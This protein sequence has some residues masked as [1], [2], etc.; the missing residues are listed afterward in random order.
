MAFSELLRIVELG[1]TVTAETTAEV[2]SGATVIKSPTTG[3]Q[4][5]GEAYIAGERFSYTE[6]TGTE[7]KGVTGVANTHA[8]KAEVTVTG[9]PKTLLN[10]ND[11]VHYLE[12]AG[13]FEVIPPEPTPVLAQNQRRWGGSREVAEVHAN[14]AIEWTAGVT[15]ATEQEAI[16]RVE[17]LLAQ[18]AA[19]PYHTYVLWQVPGASHPT[20]FEMRGTGTWTPKYDV[21][22][23]E[24]AQ[25]FLLTIRVPVAPLALGWPVQV[26]SKS[27]LTLP[28]VL[29]ITGIP[30]DAPA[31]A[32]VSIETGS[33]V[34]ETF[35]TGA[36]EPTGIAI[37]SEFIYW[38]NRETGYIGRAKLNGTGV[39][40]T[41]LHV[42][43]EPI[44]VAVDAAHI[45]WCNRAGG[46][47]GR[48]TIAGATIEKTWITGATSPAGV[49][50]DASHVYWANSAAAGTIGRAAIAGGSIEQN[51][52]TG[53]SRP[54]GLA[55]NAAH[56]YW[57][58]ESGTGIGRAT[59]AGA[60]ASQ[61]WLAV[62]AGV[63]G[64]AI[65]TEYIYWTT[66]YPTNA[67]GRA[68][69]AGAEPNDAWLAAVAEGLAVSSEYV[70]AAL[71]P[72]N[73]ILRMK[74]GGNPVFGLLGWASKPT[75]GLAKAPFG[76]LTAS[77]S[78][79]RI[80]LNL[81]SVTGGTGGKSLK[82]TTR[83]GAASWEVDPATMVPDSFSG[84]LTLEVWARI[85]VSP[86]IASLT[87]TLSAQPQDGTG[88]GAARYTDEW[89]SAGRP[90][91]L[92]EGGVTV[93][94]RTRLGTLHLVVNPLAPRIWN[95]VVE[96]RAGNEAASWGIDALYLCPSTQ[97]ACSP[98]GKANGPSYPDFIANAAATV[99]TIRSDLSA[100]VAKPGKNGHPD[101]GLGGQ[102]LELPPGE[103]KLLAML[104]S[105]VPDD[106][107]SST[108]SDQLAFE[109]KVTVWVTP[110]FFLTR[111]V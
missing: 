48:A 80:G 23:V 88:Y 96:G 91:E 94:R 97:R 84:E 36:H 7:F 65:T 13:T 82:G 95:L 45:Y 67:I 44:A 33:A 32:E 42:E 15:A 106:P 9:Q 86:G 30:G 99:K 85:P 79:A 5:E 66:S 25:L 47:I 111:T 50:V 64:L 102:L 6:I 60:E 40:E 63:T 16:E 18:L 55:V 108:A 101:H 10:L 31:K 77:E 90:I 14:G 49:A 17:T 83:N 75:A 24:G 57:A 56:I 41:W 1:G 81:E 26:Y 27:A 100:L 78:S 107:T 76:V 52:I 8:T 109:A 46:D 92:P 53:A 58:N 11:G 69:L 103:T 71:P 98:S 59:I 4:S 35:I 38:A 20:L 29:A 62:P 51:W 19:N 2:K 104:A 37:N 12:E 22:K 105:L 68:T 61:S 21:A 93:F 28:E 70:Y 43:G 3:F 87:M 89:G 74:V 39:E 73:A 72:A 34:E 110:R 54:S